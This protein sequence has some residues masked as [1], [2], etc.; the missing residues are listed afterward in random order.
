ML[1]VAVREGGV[2]GELLAGP[3]SRDRGDESWGGDG[4]PLVRWASAAARSLVGSPPASM[5]P[6]LALLGW[7]D[8]GLVSERGAGVDRIGQD[9]VD[10][11][12][13]PLPSAGARPPATGIQALHDL[14]PR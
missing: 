8:C 3:V 14:P 11:A 12:E 2:A 4:D 1:G 5:V 6:V 9:L 10:T 13:R 7:D